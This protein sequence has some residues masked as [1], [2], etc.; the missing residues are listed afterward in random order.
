MDAIYIGSSI[1]SEYHFALYGNGY[2]DLYNTAN[3]RNGTF[4]Y[5]RIYKNMGGKFY[6]EKGVRRFS[7]TSE[8]IA[9]PIGVTD[10]WY[11]R[12]DAYSILFFF[13]CIS[14]FTIFLVNLFTSVFK[15]GGLLS[16]LL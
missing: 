6:Y 16:G 9:S 12:D 11:N 10:K 8:T 7:L 14:I 4:T 15:K 5:Y 13:L 3:L 1:P 2:I